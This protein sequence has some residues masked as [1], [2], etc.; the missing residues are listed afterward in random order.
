MKLHFGPVPNTLDVDPSGEGWLQHPGWSGNCADKR[1][2]WIHAVS[3]LFIC[4]GI[5]FG[6]GYWAMDP[7]NGSSF[8]KAFPPLRLAAFVL[9]TV[10]LHESIHLM[11]HPK[12][13]ISRQ[14]L[15]GYH[16]QLGGL[17]YVM[18]RGALSR[19]RIVAIKLAPFI[20][21]TCIPAFLMLVVPEFRL[22]DL[23]VPM[24]LNAGI[25]LLDL[26]TSAT[27]IRLL[28]GSAQLIQHNGVVWWR[29][30]A[31]SAQ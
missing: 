12:F 6:W 29:P 23:V 11:L 27:L 1:L 3:P 10:V 13:G 15:V 5:L 4:L 2:V 19:H 20:I 14:S 7:W 8:V 24:A 28:P 9:G 17:F 18:Y 25:S 22:G 26:H 30:A 31:S 21:L 16:F